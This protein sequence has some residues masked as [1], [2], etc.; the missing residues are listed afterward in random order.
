M[1]I[2]A[3]SQG[4]DPHPLI[5]KRLGKYDLQELLDQGGMGAIY[6]ATHF[7]TGEA[8]AI[9]M[10]GEA[11]AHDARFLARFE[12]E[13]RMGASCQ[14]DNIV[15]VLDVATEDRIAYMVMPYYSGGS[16]A[17]HIAGNPGGMPL[18]EVVCLIG[19]IGAALDY[20]HGRSI[21]H[22]DLKPGNVLLDGDGNAHIGDLGIARTMWAS[23]RH[24]QDVG[25]PEYRAPEV[26]AGSKTS[27]ASD[28]YAL[29]AI[30]CELLTGRDFKGDACL[31]LDHIDLPEAARNAVHRMLHPT[32]AGRYGSALAFA[33][34]LANASGITLPC[35]AGGSTS[36]GQRPKNDPVTTPVTPP[37]PHPD[38][39]HK[40]LLRETP[41]LQ[42]SREAPARTSGGASHTP[43]FVPDLV[44]SDEEI[45][46]AEKAARH[47]AQDAAQGDPAAVFIQ[48]GASLDELGRMALDDL[49]PELDFIMPD[50]L[51]EAMPHPRIPT[52]PLPLDE[53]ETPSA[54]QAPTVSWQRQSGTP[55][56]AV[57]LPPHRRSLRAT[58]TLTLQRIRGLTSSERGLVMAVTLGLVLTLLGMFI[59]VMNTIALM[60]P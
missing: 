42:L 20:L 30:A 24:P 33:S 27:P 49:P 51:D 48:D 59:L 55:A 36:N 43:P 45:R 54:A 14:H 38:T 10:V 47:P 22:R 1:T 60:L 31:A 37:T 50:R 19:Q 35:S 13:A 57:A 34:A 12:H 26:T 52:P 2:Q 15:S 18:D 28:Y 44:T 58:T 39:P 4:S 8:V 11:F 17:A 53:D 32:P 9:K 5:G 56:P 16:L 6:R 23:E 41:L 40:T 29:G 7:E 25:T 21:I 3:P 46:R